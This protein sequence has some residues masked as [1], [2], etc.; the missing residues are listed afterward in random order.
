[1]P[2]LLL[3]TS[4]S[5][6]T[7]TRVECF[8]LPSILLT[9]NVRHIDYFSL[10]IGGAEIDIL[11]TVPF[12]DVTID[13]FTVAFKQPGMSNIE[14]KQSLNGIKSFFQETRMYDYVGVIP[15]ARKGEESSASDAVFKKRLIS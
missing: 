14:R 1:M 11:R 3:Q 8:P 12:N 7:I 10:D 9:A 13:T 5:S 15:N 2:W 4:D 6:Q